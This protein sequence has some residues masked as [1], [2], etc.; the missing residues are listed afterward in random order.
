MQWEYHATPRELYF[1]RIKGHGNASIERQKCFP[2][3]CLEEKSCMD[4]SENLILPCKE[5]NGERKGTGFLL[6]S[7]AASC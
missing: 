2:K 3:T 4:Q 6:Y 1:H 7:F 5:G